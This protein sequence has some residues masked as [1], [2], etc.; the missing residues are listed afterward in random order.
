MTLDITGITKGYGAIPVLKNLNF[1]VGTGEVFAIIGPNGAGKSTLFKVVTGEVFAERGTIRYGGQ[2][3]TRMPAYQRTALGFGRTFQV[4]R[5]FPASTVT[6]N[7]VVAIEA[8]RRQKGEHTA[9]WYQV[10]LQRDLLDEAHRTAA[11]LGLGEKG[12]VEARFL[13]HGD[14]KRLEIAM[15]LALRPRVVL[16]DEPTAGMSP[17]D[18]RETVAI[19]TEVTRKHQ[20]T[21]MLTEHD[22]DVVFGLADRIMVMNY[23]E[24]IAIGSVQAVRSDPA[25]RALYL[26]EDA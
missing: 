1:S 12:E 3:I 22:M 7:I 2:D 15:V 11:S 16:L 10:R 21:V 14:R 26:G 19:L 9:A 4:A 6:E 18:R 5:V 8:R 25:V 23:G 24:I 17:E 20:L 13:S